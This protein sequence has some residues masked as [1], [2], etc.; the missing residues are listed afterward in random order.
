MISSTEVVKERALACKGCEK[1]TAVV[2][3]CKE[4]GCFMPAKIL[5]ANMTCPIGKW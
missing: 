2:H 3:V 4:C 5:L 1:L